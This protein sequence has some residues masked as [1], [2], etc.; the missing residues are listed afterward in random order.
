MY[1]LNKDLKNLKSRWIEFTGRVTDQELYRFYGRCKA[2]LALAIDEDFGITPVEAMA[3]G[4]P[5]IA[6]KGGGYLE[7]VIEGRTGE[8]F[9]KSTTENLANVLKKFDSEKYKSKDCQ[10]QA[11]KFSKERFKKEIKRFIQ[12]YA[13]TSRS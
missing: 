8:F 2:F 7:T 5:V 10:R 13:G 4:R 11:E 1:W 6:F 12:K 3:A 9:T